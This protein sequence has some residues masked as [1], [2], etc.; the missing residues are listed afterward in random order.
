[1][2]PTKNDCSQCLL[3]SC[4]ASYTC[5][6]PCLHPLQL[7]NSCDCRWLNQTPVLHTAP[8]TAEPVK[9]GVNAANGHEKAL[10]RPRSGSGLK[11]RR[12]T[13]VTDA[14]SNNCSK[15]VT[16]LPAAVA[17]PV[18]STREV[19]LLPS[20]QRERRIPGRLL[21]WSCSACTFKNQVGRTSLH[22]LF[23]SSS[24]FLCITQLT[25]EIVM[26]GSR[27]SKPCRR[28][29]KSTQT[30]RHVQVPLRVLKGISFCISRKPD[31]RMVCNVTRRITKAGDVHLLT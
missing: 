29:M 9:D 16:A 31:N 12:S 23:L 7:I 24:P 15:H 19:K 21:P 11:A 14:Y 3:D 18:S 1:M 20:Q 28:S 22:H 8:Q 26:I 30:G 6:L 13:S 27:A 5:P 17:L 4:S 10:L 2:I 25:F